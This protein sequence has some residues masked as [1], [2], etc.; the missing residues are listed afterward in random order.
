MPAQM[1]E[2]RKNYIGIL[3]DGVEEPGTT[4]SP[5]K[6]SHR[7]KDFFLGLLAALLHRRGD[8]R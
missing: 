8:A 1:Q 4:Q 3:T 5:A 2:R 6:S 7:M